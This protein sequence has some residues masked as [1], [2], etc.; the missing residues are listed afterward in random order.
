ML[1]YE[2]F[3]NSSAGYGSSQNP[4]NFK[5]TYSISPLHNIRAPANESIQYPA[6]FIPTSNEYPIPLA[7]KYVAELQNTLGKNPKQVGS[8]LKNTPKYD[9]NSKL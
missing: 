2:A 8:G 7:F 3:T 4:E 6:I 5:R 9:F 1:R